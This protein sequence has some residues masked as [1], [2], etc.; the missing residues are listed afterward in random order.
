MMSGEHIV[1]IT[2][3]C[4]DGRVFHHDWS[5]NDVRLFNN[6]VV[7][8]RD[9]K[10]TIKVVRNGLRRFVYRDDIEIGYIRPH[11]YGQ[12]ADLFGEDRCLVIEQEFSIYTPH[13]KGDG[14]Y[15]RKHLHSAKAELS[16]DFS[17]MKFAFCFYRLMEDF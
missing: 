3:K 15:F 7:H 14:F 8:D 9:D 12:G 16:R 11:F 5:K 4:S 2:A 1:R 6:F 17:V 10:P 13:F